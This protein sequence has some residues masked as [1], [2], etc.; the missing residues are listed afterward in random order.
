MMPLSLL[1]ALALQVS[2]VGLAW[3]ANPPIQQVT[4]YNIYRS[5]TTPVNPTTATKLNL[6]PIPGTTFR[7]M[8]VQQG[9]T[10]YYIVQAYRS[11]DDSE[12]FPSNE[13]RVTVA[14]PALTP[15]VNLRVTP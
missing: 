5:M 11:S 3:D 2:S 15:P 8:T 13:V 4:G 6:A 12:S 1:F 9:Q 7:D 14:L 10:Y